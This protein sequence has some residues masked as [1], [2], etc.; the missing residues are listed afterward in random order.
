MQQKWEHRALLAV[1]PNLHA[2]QLEAVCDLGDHS[3]HALR[4]IRIGAVQ[5]IAGG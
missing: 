3:D 2:G 5:S 1:T 4:G